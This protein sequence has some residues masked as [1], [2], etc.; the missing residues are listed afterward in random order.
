MILI[1]LLS[2]NRGRLFKLTLI[3]GVFTA[4]IFTSC[5]D[6]NSI[7]NGTFKPDE[8]NTIFK[9]HKNYFDTIIKDYIKF[10][11]WNAGDPP[12]VLRDTAYLYIS[13]NPQYEYNVSTGARIGGISNEVQA[14][15]DCDGPAPYNVYMG[16]AFSQTN[17]L[18]SG[19]TIPNQVVKQVNAAG[20][21]YR[22]DYRIAIPLTGVT[23]LNAY[24]GQNGGTH[25]TYTTVAATPWH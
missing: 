15:C 20:T 2:K 3:L 18:V 8:L 22:Y 17:G 4:L 5:T 24:E 23:G 6:R 1:Q 16:I 25:E 19:G 13:K 7:V 21:A 11:L 10:H 14:T 12:I 9:N